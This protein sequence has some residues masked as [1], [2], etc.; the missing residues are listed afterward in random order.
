MD[1][2]TFVDDWAIGYKLIKIEVTGN[3]SMVKHTIKPKMFLFHHNHNRGWLNETTGHKT[4]SG[5]PLMENL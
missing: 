4:D 3:T 1:F 5:Y 2:D